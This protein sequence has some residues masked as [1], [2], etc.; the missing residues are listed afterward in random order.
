MHGNQAPTEGPLQTGEGSQ[1]TLK[2][3]NSMADELRLVKQALAE[4]TNEKTSLKKQH[5]TAL[6]QLD[7]PKKSH[8]STVADFMVSE[9]IIERLEEEKVELKQ[10]LS[11]FQKFKK[12]LE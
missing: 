2:F 6:R 3:F 9:I 5:V 10:V 8:N 11:E 7:K 4:A 1:E 12:C